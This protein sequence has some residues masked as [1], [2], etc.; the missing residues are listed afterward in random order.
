M[1]NRLLTGIVLLS[2]TLHCFSRIGFLSYLYQQRHEIAFAVGLIKEVPI[3]MCSSEYDPD[4]GLVIHQ[5]GEH[6]SLPST[7]RANEITLFVSKENPPVNFSLLFL[8]TLS[9]TPFC[10]NDP[11]RSTSNIFQPPRG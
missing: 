11:S 9:Q 10:E 1:I 8:R 2:M 4:S 7:L 6:H 3:A 5:D